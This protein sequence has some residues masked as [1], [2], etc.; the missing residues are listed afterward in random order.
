[1]SNE[2]KENVKVRFSR[3]GMCD[4]A[5]LDI[6]RSEKETAASATKQ[7]EALGFV[8][9]F[10]IDGLAGT[11]ASK[12][13][14]MES[15]K[16]RWARADAAA[17]AKSVAKGKPVAGET[18]EGGKMIAAT[19]RDDSALVTSAIDAR[20]ASGMLSRLLDERGA[21][22]EESAPTEKHFELIS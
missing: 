20:E 17:E 2:G 6:F 16:D 22:A 11:E 5:A 14:L 18:A 13:C 15:K 7:F 1:M 8:P 9:E 19:A 10:G 21:Q 4:P 12:P 3:G